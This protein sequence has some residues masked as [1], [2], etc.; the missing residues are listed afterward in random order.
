MIPLVGR[1]APRVFVLIGLFWVTLTLGFEYLF[2]HYVLGKSWTAINA[3]FNV[4]D[5][6]LFIAA[7]LSAG[8]APWAVARAK[9]LADR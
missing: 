3:V 8:V 7:L 9:G 6:N 1:Q 5:G 2:G 4:S